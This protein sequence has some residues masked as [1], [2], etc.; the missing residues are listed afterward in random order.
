LRQP[1]QPQIGQCAQIL[2]R[3]LD[4]RP[5]R[6]TCRAA[7]PPRRPARPQHWVRPVAP[8]PAPPPRSAAAR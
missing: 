7:A 6:P 8:A 1:V 5:H 3:A 4:H 2:K